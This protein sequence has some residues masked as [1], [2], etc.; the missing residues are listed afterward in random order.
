MYSCLEHVEEVLDRY[1]D[2]FAKLPLLCEIE[3]GYCCSFCKQG[4]IYQIVE[5]S[6]ME[7][8]E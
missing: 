6:M 8:Y 2:D 3:A 4:A 7:D 1:L 5:G